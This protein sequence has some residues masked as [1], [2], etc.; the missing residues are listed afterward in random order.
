MYR[1]GHGK[2]SKSGGGFKKALGPVALVALG[3]AVVFAI[4][5]G[6]KLYN[7]ADKPADGP[8]STPKVSTPAPTTP[9]STGTQPTP[10]KTE[11]KT[12]PPDPNKPILDARAHID[13]SG[14]AAKTMT[15]T[16]YY[17]D[18]LQKL[19]SLQPVEIL[20]AQTNSMIKA[21]A[22]QV[23]NAPENV[24]LYSNVPPGTKVQSVN[25]DPKTGVATVDLSA[26]AARVQ[27]SAAASTMRATFVYSLTTLK[28]VKAVQLWVNGRPAMLHEV[29]W[30]K[31]ISRADLEKLSPSWK[32]EPLVKFA[33]KA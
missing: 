15:V 3:L 13:H 18:G 31:P 21:I 11:T 12:P 5:Y 10:P 22:E 14:G 2:K 25:W 4:G 16:M 32:I 33:G 17:A 23:V 26:E 20:V 8:V 30:S 19:E 24:K 6:A 7:P 28:D 1:A 29:E 27:G 9:G